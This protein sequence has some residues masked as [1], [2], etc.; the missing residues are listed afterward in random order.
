[1]LQLRRTAA[2][3]FVFY[4]LLLT[5]GIFVC[6][7]HCIGE[8]IFKQKTCISSD[9]NDDDEISTVPH[10][11]HENPCKDGKDC[12]CC[13]HHDNFVVKEN[14]SPGFNLVAPN[15]AI[16]TYYQLF[17]SLIFRNPEISKW[18]FY[19]SNAPPQPSGKSIIFRLCT[20]LI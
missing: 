4:Y 7:V 12:S 17:R 14:I 9:D 16:I 2:I 20:I 1:M 5:T 3:F 6:V 8:D 11:S 18:S 10:K 13:A 19:E 15:V